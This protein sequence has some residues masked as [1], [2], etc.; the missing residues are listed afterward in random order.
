MHGN[1]WEWCADD[2][3]N[4]YKNAP[5]DGSPWLNK[6]DNRSRKIIRGGS[7]YDLPNN[8]RSANRFNG[9]TDYDDDN[10]GFRVVLGVPRT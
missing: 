3:H 4:D 10:I 6:N 5:N 9:N 8:C 7:W 1:V 2:R